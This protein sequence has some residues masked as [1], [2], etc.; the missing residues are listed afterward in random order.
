MNP[1][2]GNPVW[3]LSV[4]SV[5]IDFKTCFVFIYIYIYISYWMLDPQFVSLHTL[6]M[7]SSFE[8]FN[9]ERRTGTAEI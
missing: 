2:D 7:A 8:D 9:K 4:C 1:S 5:R 6:T 3:S